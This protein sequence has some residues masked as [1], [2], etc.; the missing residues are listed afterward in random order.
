MKFCF[1]YPFSLL[2]LRLSFPCEER[3]PGLFVKADKVGT[4]KD[5]QSICECSVLVVMSFP[6]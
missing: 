6:G 3:V 2:Q 5:I 1:S 4:K